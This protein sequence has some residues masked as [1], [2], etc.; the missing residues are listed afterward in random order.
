MFGRYKLSVHICRNNVA[1]LHCRSAAVE[2]RRIAHIRRASQH[3]VH[4]AKV[5]SQLD[6]NVP[7]RKNCTREEENCTCEEEFDQ[8]ATVAQ[9][10]TNKN[11]ESQRNPP[12][13]QEL[14]TKI[15]LHPLK[16]DHILNRAKFSQD[17]SS[18]PKVKK[19]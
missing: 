15:C 19:C 9:A 8:R 2:F 7:V 12:I 16:S 3:G 18:L 14:K 6:S 17:I 1:D 10:G 5:T 13:S 11:S 4:M